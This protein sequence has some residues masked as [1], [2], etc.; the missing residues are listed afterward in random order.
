[1]TAMFDFDE[2]R[3]IC[4]DLAVPFDDL[5]GDTLSRKSLSLY[6]FMERRG[7]LYRLAAVCQEKRPDGNW[8]VT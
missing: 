1:M 2:I 5:G 3:E 6:E 4:F 7:D 8:T